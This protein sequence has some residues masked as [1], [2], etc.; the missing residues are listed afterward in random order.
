MKRPA[1]RRSL[2]PGVSRFAR[3]WLE[4]AGGGQ[5]SCFAWLFACLPRPRLA[6]FRLH[7]PSRRR[8]PAL[9]P[10]G[11][12][13]LARLRPRQKAELVAS[14]IPSAASMSYDAKR[15]RLVIPM[16]DWNA[17]TFVEF[18][19]PAGHLGRPAG[20]SQGLRPAR[21]AG[22]HRQGDNRDSRVR[23]LRPARV[24]AGREDVRLAG[25]RRRS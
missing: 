15:N 25:R 4:A 12:S 9:P 5:P 19:Q 14:G 24:N 16:N 3:R 20:A 23:A 1:P 10:R 13:P 2:G 6:A 11:R 7:T 21:P 8:H 17:I 22:R 18:S